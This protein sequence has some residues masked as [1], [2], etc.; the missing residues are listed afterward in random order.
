MISRKEIARELEML[1]I[2]EKL[3][4]RVSHSRSKRQK[5]KMKKIELQEELKPSTLVQVNYVVAIYIKTTLA[6]LQLFYS[7]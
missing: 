6:K 4:H 5:N 2:L 3:V 1:K 7:L